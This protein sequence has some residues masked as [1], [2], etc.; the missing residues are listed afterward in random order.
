[1]TAQATFAHRFVLE[2]KWAALGGMTLETSLVV[3]KQRGAA[4]LE[5]LRQICAAALDG[6]ALVRV[7]AISAAH[8]AFEHRMVM[9]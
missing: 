3:A 4:A 5:T 8:F 6:V 7:M 1:M 2:N 9:R